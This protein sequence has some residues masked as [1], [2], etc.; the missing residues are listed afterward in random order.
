MLYVLLSALTII[1]SIFL[2]RYSFSP[3]KKKN[4]DFQHSLSTPKKHTKSS[5]KS[6][7]VLNDDRII[8]NLK[9]EN[10]F[11]LRYSI[12]DLEMSLYDGNSI[13]KS[14]V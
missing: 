8:D 1:L 5:I 4:D 6:R 3:K 12:E 14:K 11:K 7:L 2:A 13:I 9:V 10:N